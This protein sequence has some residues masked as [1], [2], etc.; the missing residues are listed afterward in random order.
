MS[1]LL[2]V[3][4]IHM[5]PSERR[6]PFNIGSNMNIESHIQLIRTRKNELQNIITFYKSTKICIN[7]SII[8]AMMRHIF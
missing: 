2:F 6:T 7:N 8:P 1:V 3:F 5:L 4:V